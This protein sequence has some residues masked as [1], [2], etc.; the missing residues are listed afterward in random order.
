MNTVFAY[1]YLTLSMKHMKKGYGKIGNKMSTTDS[2]HWGTDIFKRLTLLFLLNTINITR[3]A[4]TIQFF[5]QKK[6]R[7]MNQGCCW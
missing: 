6:T 4:K 5:R 2:Y 7:K 1:I 3:F